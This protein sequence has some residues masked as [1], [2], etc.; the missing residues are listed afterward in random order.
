MR[1]AALL[2]LIAAL[3]CAAPGTATGPGEPARGTPRLVAAFDDAR[4]DA[5]GPGSYVPPGDTSFQPGDFDLRRFAV[6]VDG[7]DVLFEVT[8]GA[9]IR[10]PQDLYRLN[11]TPARLWNNLYL[12]NI[13]IYL[14]TDPTSP[15]GHTA[16][17]PGR[18]VAFAGGRTWK[19]AVILTPQPGLAQA[20]VADALPAASKKMIFPDRLQLRGRP[21]VARIPAD[22]LGGLPTPA[23][24]Y[25]VHV[26]G[27]TWERNLR[28]LDRLTGTVEADAFTMPILSLREA[29]TFGGAPDNDAFPR[30]VDVL[31]PPGVDQR[32]VLGS[33]QAVSGAWARVPFVYAQPPGAPTPPG[34]SLDAA[35]TTPRTEFKVVDV[36]GTTV[37]VAGPVK[38]LQP[39]QLGQ[40][41]GPKGEPVARLVIVQ[42]L[43]KG[44]V[45]SVVDGADR[46][47]AGAQVRFE[48]PGASAPPQAR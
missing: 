30:V 43:D 5:W 31:L 16:C 36:S 26:S 41:L 3:G 20:V 29:W 10:V 45:A 28:A 25:S 27:A 47:A 37:T 48:K 6:L 44:V 17:V 4:D 32:E 35:A 11:S 38:G 2:P 13:D 42:L 9:E 34:A 18:R 7:D 39:M 21:L 12:Q 33:Y 15:A 40:V 8:L 22:Q 23:W 1:L 24:G 19:R 14:D 46:I